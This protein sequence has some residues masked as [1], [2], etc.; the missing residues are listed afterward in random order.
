MNTFKF[1][2]ETSIIIYGFGKA[3]KNL[4]S[5]LI[6]NGYKVA[7][8]VD[9]NASKLKMDYGAF[10][11]HPDELTQEHMKHIFILTFQNILE[12]EKT[13]KVLHD[14]GADKIIYLKRSIG[15]MYKRHFE[16]YNSLVYTEGIDDFE[17]EYTKFLHEDKKTLFY[18]Q[19]GEY[20]VTEAPAAII[21]RART[22][23]NTTKNILA[24]NEYNAVLELVLKG[25]TDNFD[26]FKRYCESTCGTERSIESFLQDRVRLFDM[27]LEEYRQKGISFF[28]YSPATAEWNPKGFFNLTDGHHRAVFL[29][30]MLNCNIPIKITKQDYDK[31]VNHEWAQKCKKYIKEHN[32]KKTFTPVINPEFYDIESVTENRGRLTSSALYKFFSRQS[33]DGYSILDVNSNLSYYSQ[34]FS[35]MGAGKIVSLEKRD[36]LF[37]LAVM[38]N[39]LHSTVDI[40]MRNL[41]LTELDE[42]TKYDIVILANDLLLN[43]NVGAGTRALIEKID[44]LSSKY[45]IWRSFADA[46][47][48][49]RFILENSGFEKY[50]LLNTEIIEG[51]LVEAGVYEKL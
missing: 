50:H 33:V 5:K 6:K 20:I 18:Y 31:W 39:K 29:A 34:L 49:K 23:Q 36:L 30:N 37:N 7:G 40:D 3:G 46:E 45:F 27:M 35:R 4:Y 43:L 26:D 9:R 28:R 1:N 48:E 22:D 24:F 25:Q 51:K 12:Q 16:A 38:L 10:I 14:R 32:I 19:T 44:R 13:A 8:V 17:F 21:F 47:N 15:S 42:G 11:M 41:D 2:K